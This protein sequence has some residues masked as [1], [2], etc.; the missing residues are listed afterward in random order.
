ML[1]LVL[2]HQGKYE[3]AAEINQRAL[4]RREKA[5]GVDHPDT[6]ISVNNLALA[7]RY[8]G[9]YEQ[10]EETNRRALE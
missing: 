4:T 5:L 6:L 9:K 8:Q 1:T 10:A 2:R 7:L 3:Q